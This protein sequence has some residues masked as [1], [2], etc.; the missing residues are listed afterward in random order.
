MSKTYILKLTSALCISGVV[1]RAGELV[2]VSELEA[3][4]FLARG[5]AELAT[6]D[7]ADLTVEQEA[8][9]DDEL[10]KLNKEQLLAKAKELGVD[11]GS[12]A[13][14]TQIIEAIKAKADGEKGEE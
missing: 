7:E 8:P 13:S 5:K 11:I 14:K 9:A 2:E 3:K 12:G 6:A 1:C 10:S 4:N